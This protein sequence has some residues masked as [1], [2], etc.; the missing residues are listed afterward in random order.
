[1]SILQ[2][3][4]VVVSISIICLLIAFIIIEFIIG[5]YK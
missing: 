5:E 3:L 4:G 1:M 2:G